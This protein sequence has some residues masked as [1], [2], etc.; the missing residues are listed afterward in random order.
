MSGVPPGG[1]VTMT[2]TGLDGKLWHH[3]AG[4]HAAASANTTSLLRNIES[5]PPGSIPADAS[6]ISPNTTPPAT[7]APLLKKGG[8]RKEKAAR[9]C[10]WA[11]SEHQTPRF[12][13]VLRLL[14]Y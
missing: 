5:Y 12:F 10:C 11:A 6:R 8:D 14:P 2:R 4:R 3:A 13:L 9:F 7:R 1:K